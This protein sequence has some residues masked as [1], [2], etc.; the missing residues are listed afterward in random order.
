MKVTSYLPIIRPGV[1]TMMDVIAEETPIALQYNGIS[2][3]VML[4]TPADLE[5]MVLGFS[6]SEGIVDRAEDIFDIDI[7]HAEEGITLA[8]KIAGAPFWRLKEVRRSMAGRTGCGLCGKESLTHVMRDLRPVVS[9]G[10]IPVTALY[11]GLRRLPT[12]QYLQGV[13]GAV[14]AAC[15]VDGSGSID[16]V[17]E[18]IGRHNALDKSIGAIL[19]SGN[20]SDAA[21]MITSRASFEMVQKVA[22]CGFGLLA[23]LSAPTASAVRLA[24]RLNITLVGFLRGEDCVVYTHPQRLQGAQV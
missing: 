12:Q 18:D 14:H 4:A 8:I 20:Q 5:D 17:R 3:A 24:E 19:R 10:P 11:E 13:T 23:A 6:M 15:Q 1:S 16:F 22:A 21:I 7:Q 9:R 2:H